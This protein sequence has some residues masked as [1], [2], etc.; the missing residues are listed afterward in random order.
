MMPPMAG[1][2]AHEHETGQ[3]PGLLEWE[4]LRQASEC[5]KTLA[6][7]VRLRRVEMLLRDRYTVGE[8]ALACEIPSHTASGHLRL[9]ERS[10]LL[11][12]KKEGRKVYYRVAEP[13]LAHIIACVEGRF[14]E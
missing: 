12:S 14:G 9:M 6:H 1:E 7:P 10:G 13:H 3:E 4:A 2:A 8:L 11:A 5:L